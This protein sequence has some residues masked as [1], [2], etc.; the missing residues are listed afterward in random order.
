VRPKAFVLHHVRLDFGVKVPLFA[1]MR[2]DSH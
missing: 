2:T 1:P